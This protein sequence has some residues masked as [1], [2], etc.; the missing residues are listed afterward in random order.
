VGWVAEVLS[1][2]S[3][4]DAIGRGR[5]WKD[6]EGS[7]IRNRKVMVFDLRGVADAVRFLD[8]C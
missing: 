3:G 7:A 4:M 5:R 6:A 2:A 1:E 8:A